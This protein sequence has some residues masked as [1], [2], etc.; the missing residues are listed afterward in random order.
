[1]QAT[2]WTV[3]AP[4]TNETAHGGSVPWP[5]SEILMRR[6]RVL[7]SQQHQRERYETSDLQC[8]IRLLYL[9]FGQWPTATARTRALMMSM[10]T[11]LLLLLSS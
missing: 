11:I 2:S 3:V 8:T 4:Q 9:T 5:Q 6:L 10:M 1:M 7:R